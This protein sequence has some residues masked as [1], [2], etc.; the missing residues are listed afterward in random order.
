MHRMRWIGEAE[1]RECVA[2]QEVAEV[3]G[4]PGD[5]DR[6]SDQEDQSQYN[7]QGGEEAHAKDCAGG[8][9]L[10]GLFNWFVKEEQQHY[11]RSQSKRHEIDGG[12]PQRISGGLKVPEDGRLNHC[13]RVINVPGTPVLCF[14]QGVCE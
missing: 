13:D 11:Q 1:M 14:W 4:Y 9:P 5:G 7:W 10:R 6:V 12:E 2:Q 3:I 8:D